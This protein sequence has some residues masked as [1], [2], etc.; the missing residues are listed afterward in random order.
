MEIAFGPEIPSSYNEKDY[1]LWKWRKNQVNQAKAL[2][3][4]GV[5]TA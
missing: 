5:G 1:I 4:F 2:D 3:W